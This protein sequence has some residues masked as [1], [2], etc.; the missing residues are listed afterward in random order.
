MCVPWWGNFPQYSKKCSFILLKL[1]VFSLNFLELKHCFRTFHTNLFLF[2]KTSSTWKMYWF[3]RKLYKNITNFISQWSKNMVCFTNVFQCFAVLI[4]HYKILNS[5]LFIF[6][7]KVISSFIERRIYG[8][9][10]MLLWTQH[11]HTFFHTFSTIHQNNISLLVC[12]LAPLRWTPHLFG[13]YAVPNEHDS[14]ASRRRACT[15]VTF[16]ALPARR[17][18]TTTTQL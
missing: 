18:L 2:C 14:E 3:I 10:R 17:C 15:A 16:Q 1:C 4:F 9:F 12:C 13:I 7:N 6:S 5:W 8:Q 11:V